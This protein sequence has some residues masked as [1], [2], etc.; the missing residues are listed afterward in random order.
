MVLTGLCPFKAI[1]KKTNHISDQSLVALCV[2]T[3]T[4]SSAKKAAN[5]FEGKFIFGKRHR[6]LQ[7]IG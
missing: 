1:A 3:P 2:N 6:Y 4:T 7:A 5:Y